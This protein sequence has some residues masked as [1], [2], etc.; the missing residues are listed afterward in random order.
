VTHPDADGMAQSRRGTSFAN[1]SKS[2][3]RAVI[4]FDH[5]AIL[6]HYA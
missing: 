4:V 1:F 3:Y 6:L 5:A 2:G